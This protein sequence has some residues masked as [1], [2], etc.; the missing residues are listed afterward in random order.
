[1]ETGDESSLA[2]YWKSENAYRTFQFS[3]R[4]LSFVFM[5]SKYLSPAMRH[6]A[7]T[8]G[9][10]VDAD[11]PIGDRYLE[12]IDHEPFFVLIEEG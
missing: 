11:G 10:I 2:L 4:S 8:A 3:P 6:A 12:K 5:V 9:G 1:M 7:R